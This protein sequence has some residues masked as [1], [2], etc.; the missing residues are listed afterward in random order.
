MK[1][2]AI[3]AGGG[4]AWLFPQ[5]GWADAATPIELSKPRIARDRAPVVNAVEAEPSAVA[6]GG[7]PSERAPGQGKLNAA[8]TAHGLPPSPALRDAIAKRA[9][10]N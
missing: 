4:V 9:A 8:L 10:S 3:L 5:T 7:A 1:L 2:A 6:N